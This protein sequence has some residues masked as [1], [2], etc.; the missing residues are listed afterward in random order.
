[1]STIVRVINEKIFKLHVKGSPEKIF[2]LC[3][4]ASIPSTFHAVLDFYAK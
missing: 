2:E 1:M 4:P 3:D